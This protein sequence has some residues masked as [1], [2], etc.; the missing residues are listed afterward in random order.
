MKRILVLGLALASC[1]APLSAPPKTTPPMN[2][3]RIPFTYTSVVPLENASA[4]QI[5]KTLNDLMDTAARLASERGRGS[6]VLYPPGVEWPRPEPPRYVVADPRTNSLLV[7][8][9]PDEFPRLLEFISK[10]DARPQ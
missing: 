7:Q 9:T 5:A 1:A 2:P 10:L 6:C 3:I 4:E 8:A